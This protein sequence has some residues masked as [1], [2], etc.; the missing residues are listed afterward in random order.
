M[1]NLSEVLLSDE[2]YFNGNNG[3][4]SRKV[5]KK[6]TSVITT[7]TIL[8]ETPIVQTNISFTCADGHTLNEPVL[9][10][11]EAELILSYVDR[12]KYDIAVSADKKTYTITAK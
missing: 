11:S 5:T 1:K 12:S 3:I 7:E 10:E 9:F 8:S 4:F 6:T 2:F